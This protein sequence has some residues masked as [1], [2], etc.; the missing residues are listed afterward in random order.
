[1]RINIKYNHSEYNCINECLIHRGESS[2]VIKLKLI[3]DNKPITELVAKASQGN[4]D[5]TTEVKRMLE[6]PP[7]LE[8]N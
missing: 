7:K 6:I 1:M 2:H 5:L 8:W 4:L 3:I